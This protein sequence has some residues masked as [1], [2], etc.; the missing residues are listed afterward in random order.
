MK[1]QFE[2][3]TSV[4]TNFADAQR[5]VT[6]A[7][8]SNGSATKEN[9]AYMD[10]MSAKLNLMK[11]QFQE[12]VL[13]DGGL[14]NV[15]KWFLDVGIAILKFANS[16]VG[17]L[18]IQTTALISTIALLNKGFI[19]LKESTKLLQLT[20]L[21][22]DIM[23]LKSGMT[24]VVSSQFALDI[25][26]K[27]LTK[28][29]LDN[30]AAWAMTP[31]GMITIAVGAV[32]T[33][34]TAFDHFNASRDERIEKLNEAKSA[35]ESALGEFERLESQLKSVRDRIDEIN[36]KD[37]LSITDETQLRLLQEEEASL[38]HQVLLQ[39]ELTRAAKEEATTEAKKTLSKT[40]QNAEIFGLERPTE[41]GRQEW[42]A[43]SGTVVEAVENITQKIN[44][45]QDAIDS[46][47]IAKKTLENA[48][49]TESDS[50]KEINYS[51]AKHIARR[52]EL[53]N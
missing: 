35:Y 22:K 12:L 6:L 7:I 5:A 33:L 1:N 48:N 51:I 25:A 18:I 17:Q 44:D 28:T 50:Y 14:Q 29:L 16:D 21:I 37:N 43:G 30:A 11:A 15:A 39:Q 40:F 45:E 4:L 46:L 10:S 49:M 52:D 32:M 2:V 13:G 53:R 19:A 47:L 34:K 24:T 8:E 20:T 42:V 41:P 38:E 3:F 31:F 9:E 23:A 26:T 27:G 36:N